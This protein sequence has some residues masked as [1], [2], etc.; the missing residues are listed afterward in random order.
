MTISVTSLSRLPE[1]RLH[2]ETRPQRESLPAPWEAR[3]G[4]A[5][6]AIC[7]FM[8][9]RDATATTRL[10]RRRQRLSRCS[11][12]SHMMEKHYRLNVD[13]SISVYHSM[14][15]DGLRLLNDKSLTLSS[16]KHHTLHI[17]PLFRIMLGFP[18][19]CLQYA[20][21]SPSTLAP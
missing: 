11:L 3:R 1:R 18:G 17:T 21:C 7:F 20:H 10:P 14:T 5:R 19:P 8:P 4:E 2:R 16:L 15:E 6:V 9:P 13:N 12:R